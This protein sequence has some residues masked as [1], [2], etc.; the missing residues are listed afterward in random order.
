MPAHMA[1]TKP[2][3]HLLLQAY[4]DISR[5]SQETIY[6]D[7]DA[8][9]RMRKLNSKNFTERVLHHLLQA[10]VLS[11]WLQQR[12]SVPVTE[13]LDH[14]EAQEF[15]QLLNQ[16]YSGELEPIPFNPYL[17]EEFGEKKIGDGQKRMKDYFPFKLSQVQAGLP[18]PPLPVGTAAP[19]IICPKQLVVSLMTETYSKEIERLLETN[20]QK[21]KNLERNPLDGFKMNISKSVNKKRQGSSVASCIL[22]NVQLLREILT[23]KTT[24]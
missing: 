20:N 19:V 21:L 13:A 16:A 2:S 14:A 4:V 10:Q 12:Y 6:E 23:G 22:S 3:S 18:T 24:V 11:G 7:D 5:Q 8:A 9:E 1:H 17:K 15:A